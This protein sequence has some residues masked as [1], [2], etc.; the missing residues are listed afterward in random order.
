MRFTAAALTGNAIAKRLTLTV[1]TAETAFTLWFALAWA[2]AAT[3]FAIIHAR[4]AL[5]FET[6]NHFSLQFLSGV[7]LNFAQQVAVSA[8]LRAGEQVVVQQS[9]TVKA[10]IGKAGASHEH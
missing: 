2:F 10:D 1:I 9:Y 5:R 6:S 8:G 3:A 7:L 4:C